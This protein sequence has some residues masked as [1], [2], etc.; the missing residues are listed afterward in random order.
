[1]KKN[2]FR[3]LLVLVLFGVSSCGI[4]SDIMFRTP[5]GNNPNLTKGY[6]TIS[7]DSL[8]TKSEADY[9][10]TIDDQIQLTISPN[11][12]RQIIEAAT[13]T[14]ENATRT[15]SQLGNLAYT[16]RTD[17]YV[18]LPVLGDVYLNQLTIR[19][20]EDS[21]RKWYGKYY[22]DPFVIVTVTNKRVIIF[23]G[24]GG[25]AKVIPLTN[26]NTRLMEVIAQA[27][28]IAQRGKAKSIKLMRSINGER[29]VIPI[30]LSKINNIAYSDIIVQGNDY[31]YVEPHPRVARQ[32]LQETTPFFSFISSVLL[33]F[34]YFSK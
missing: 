4:N 33:L 14:S 7:P 18:N 22:I 25:D 6:R 26:N 32:I 2:A 20:S 29:V 31:I 15:S 12:G 28:G 24:G 5:K 23:P 19:Q 21:L 13:L 9:R 8:P 27:G 16:I 3:L 30:D 17:G 11:D 34:N 10:L 1:M